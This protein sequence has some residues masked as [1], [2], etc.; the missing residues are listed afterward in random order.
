[1]ALS[2]VMLST[3]ALIFPYAID[4]VLAITN[5]SFSLSCMAGNDASGIVTTMPSLHEAEKAGSQPSSSTDQLP[6]ASNTHLHK[7]LPSENFGEANEEFIVK[8]R[9]VSPSRK[10]V[11][12]GQAEA[13]D[14]RVNN[15]DR[16]K[17]VSCA[18]AATLLRGS[19]VTAL[20]SKETLALP[21][22][23]AS[24]VNIP[25]SEAANAVSLGTS[26]VAVAF[27]SSRSA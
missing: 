23:D 26:T 16:R 8:E 5:A 4:T 15:L 7:R 20:V 1:M 19:T 27:S 6:T 14:L 18:H 24:I 17:P 9:Y 12:H 3:T 22:A 10:T 25:L 11:R 21:E 2:A 13:E